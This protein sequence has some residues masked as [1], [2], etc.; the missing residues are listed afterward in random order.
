MSTRRPLTRRTAGIQQTRPERVVQFG[1]GNFI[2]AFVDWMLHTL[3][4]ETDF[5]G[6]VV[7]VKVTP[8]GKYD[9]LD[10]QEGLFHVHTEGIENGQF[11]ARTDLVSCISRTVYP[12]HDFDAYLALARQPEIRALVSNT[13][14]AG[15]TY[16]AEDDFAAAPPVSFPAKLTRFLHERYQYFGGSAVSG[17]IVLPTELVVANGS[18]LQGMVLRYADQW[19]LPPGFAEW[20]RAHNRFCNTLVDRIVPGYPTAKSDAILDAVGYED[21]L[22][23]LGEPYHSFVIEAPSDLT[24]DL[25]FHRTALNVRLVDDV[26]PYRQLKVRV[27]NGLHTSMVPIGYLL[28]LETVRDC[29]EHPSLGAFLKD[30]V[31]HEILPTL[32]HDADDLA[33]F[34]ASVFDRFRNPAVHHRL[35][36]IATN[37]SAK[38]RTRLLPTLLDYHARYQALP[39]HL[40]T[41]FAAFIVMYRGTW[42]GEAIP[43]SDDAALLAWF[44][45]Q[46]QAHASR[47]ALVQ[48]VLANTALWGMDLNTIAG[49]HDELTD[50]V[51]I[52]EKGNLATHLEHIV[53]ST[54]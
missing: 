22:L 46:W 19:H 50:V 4:Q 32:A 31:Q 54:S 14:E 51:T 16:R 41:A 17:C 49:L 44:G 8:H 12:Y 7:V 45:Q 6:S 26:A 47:A 2:R 21:A 37:S 5:D 15:I 27:L 43:L 30:E 24:N 29:V 3:N 20:V 48:A 25:P 52:I 13:T 10:A 39:P 40:L 9:A 38:M 1:A 23:V 42:Q 36:S 53:R 11:V 35:L 28:G 33:A 18:Q 34:A